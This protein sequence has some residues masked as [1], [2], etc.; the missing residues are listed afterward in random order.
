MC[1]LED[2]GLWEILW[3]GKDMRKKDVYDIWGLLDV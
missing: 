2:K 1:F 3:S